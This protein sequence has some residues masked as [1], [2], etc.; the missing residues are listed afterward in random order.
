MKKD[1]IEDTGGELTTIPNEKY[2]KFFSKFSEI[3]T[4][5]VSNWKAAHLLGYF[6]KKY[7]ETYGIDYQWKFNNQ[8]PTKCFEVWQFNTLCAKLSANPKV[9]KEY[10]DWAYVNIVPKAKRRLTSI[11]FLTREDIVIPYK[12]K[13]LLGDKKDLHID[14]STP[15]PSSYKSVLGTDLFTITDYGA[16]AFACQMEPKPKGLS[17]ALEKMIQL[18]FDPEILKRII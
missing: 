2:K 18:G 7:K 11:S 16:L 8:S 17:E 4:L 9:L 14:R 5:E 12:M 1:N 13:V 6:C 10:I 15:L 3:D